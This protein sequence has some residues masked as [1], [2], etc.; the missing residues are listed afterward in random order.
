MLC[1]VVQSNFR[2]YGWNPGVWLFKRKPL[3]SIFMCYFVVEG[4][5][6]TSRLKEVKPCTCFKTYHET[7]SCNKV[8]AYLS[9]NCLRDL[10][11]SWSFLIDVSK[12]RN[13]SETK[14][15]D[16][17]FSDTFTSGTPPA[18]C[19]Y[20][21]RYLINK[22]GGALLHVLI[23]HFLEVFTSDKVDTSQMQ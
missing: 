19:I 9:C 6:N 3:S 5:S 2:I 16:S 15:N 12:F 17:Y 10:T 13:Y 14:I 8:M 18:T 11:A 21:N 20:N 1:K 22:W 4:E 7:A 23:G